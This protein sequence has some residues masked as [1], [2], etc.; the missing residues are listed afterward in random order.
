MIALPRFEIG[1]VDHCNMRCRGCSHMA[2]V[3]PKGFVRPDELEEDLAFLAALIHVPKVLVTGGEPLLHPEIDLV[4]ETIRSSGLGD[5]VELIT[6]GILLPKMSRTFWA[7][8]DSVHVALYAG[9]EASWPKEYDSKVHVENVATFQESF[10]TKPND[11]PGLV[12]KIWDECG[13]RN[14]CFGLVNRHFYKCMRAGYIPRVVSQG[15]PVDG[16][17]LRGLT[18]KA[19]IARIKDPTP[20]AACRFCTGTSGASFA[21]VE[22]PR[23]A[24]IKPQDRPIGE[25]LKT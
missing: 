13:S 24:W 12:R 18:E 8:T 16:I 23:E 9:A 3:L 20:L 19:L 10:T 25:L 22:L 14:V 1:I 4:I 2:P 21:H 11:D 5:Q 6:N 15:P 17:F 7:M